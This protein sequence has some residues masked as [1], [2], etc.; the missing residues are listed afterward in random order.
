MSNL[1]ELLPAGGGGKNV[2]FVASGTLGNGKTVI[3]NSD[4]T[5]SVVV[6]SAIPASTGTP[7]VFE[8][9]LTKQ[10]SVAMLSETKAIVT[11]RDSGNSDY[12]T[13][14]I[15]DISGSTIAS[16]TPLIFESARTDNPV[17]VK[18]SSVKALVVYLD[19][20]NGNYGTSCILDVSGS[21]IT[22]GTPLVFESASTY[23]PSVSL[24]STDKVIVSYK[25]LGNGSYG[26]SII[27][28]VS[29]STITAGSA[30]VFESASTSYT[31]VA[32]LSATKAIVVHR[33]NGNSMYGTS[34]VLD[35]SGS[36]IT[37]GST[38]VFE[39]A[40]SDYNVVAMLTSTKAIVT[41]R[42]VGSTNKGTAC[43]LDVSG[44]TV[45]AGT[46]VVFETGNTTSSYV[47]MLTSTK[48]IVAYVDNDNSGYGTS[49]ILDVSGSTIT[50]GTPLV[51]NSAS[52]NYF[53]VDALDSN[54]VITA[55]ANV[56]NSSY[57]TAVVLQ[58]A[59]TGTNLT[60]TNFLGITD[61]AITSGASGSVTIKGG[62]KSELSSLTPNSIYYVQTDGSVTTAS[63]APAVRIGKALSS[64]TLNLEFSS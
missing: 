15:L 12:G 40:R 1:S 54:K 47:T 44:S 37:A 60:S 24:L 42:D 17:I 4:G 58:T 51:L 41:Y 25:D 50:A 56:G 26:T 31:S 27:L 33:D 38:I 19:N 30:V 53:S 29:G 63:T 11:Y 9:A 22:A 49:C 62:L 3:L 64:T 18:L 45:T 32:A 6:E 57:G 13:A 48:A 55:Y 7:D 35:V 28:D 36:T 8:S 16:G 52:S 39:S 5:V 59:Y 23:Y 14:C 34:C 2:D 46:P 43:I 10:I 20:G 21:T 61:A